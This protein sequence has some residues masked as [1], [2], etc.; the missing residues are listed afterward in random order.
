[1]YNCG[2]HCKKTGLEKNGPRR[3]RFPYPSNC[4][5]HCKKLGRSFLSRSQLMFPYPSNCGSHCKS[6]P[7]SN[8]ILS[9]DSCTL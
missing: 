8:K 7:F 1:M 9:I 4:G 3:D 5:S 2:S 6:A